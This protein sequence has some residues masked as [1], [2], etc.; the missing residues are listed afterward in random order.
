MIKLD[1]QFRE[2]EI[3]A[4]GSGYGT[5]EY[6]IMLSLKTFFKLLED[7]SYSHERLEK[8]LGDTV[9]WL[10]INALSRVDILEWGTS[11]RNGW[12]TSSGE[13]VKDYVQS[14]STQELYEVL[15]ED[16]EGTCLCE[17]SIKDKGHE[18]CGK[19]PMTNEKYADHLK[20]NNK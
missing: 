6:P 8:E 17:G 2:W 1:N 15:M 5:G 14:K 3:R 9:T 20:Y 10:L 18:D 12:L 11:A 7:N 19:N 16:T 4:F 13:H